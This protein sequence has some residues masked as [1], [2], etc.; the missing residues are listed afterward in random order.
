MTAGDL[1]ADLTGVGF[2]AAG[3]AA[4]LAPAEASAPTMGR[5]EAAA[6]RQ[7]LERWGNLDLDLKVEAFDQL[8]GHFGWRMTAATGGRCAVITEHGAALNAPWNLGGHEVQLLF[9]DGLI[10]EISVRLTELSPTPSPQQRLAAQD[11]FVE[12]VAI[13]TGTLGKPTARRNGRT[14]TIDWRRSSNTV[15][16]VTNGCAVSTV[17]ISNARQDMLSGGRS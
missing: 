14:Q 7:L 8:I 16:L 13:G 11:A 3:M 2:D 5:A 9:V 17:L 6:V 10:D 15:S 12:Y 1:T 4:A